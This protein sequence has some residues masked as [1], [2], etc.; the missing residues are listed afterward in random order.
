MSSLGVRRGGEEVRHWGRHRGM[1]GRPGGGRHRHGERGQVLVLF[2]LSMFVILGASAVAVDAS[3]WWYNQQ[4]MHRAA[5]AAALAGAI[6]LPGNPTAAANVAKAE[7]GK[8]DYLHGLQGVTVAAV[9]EPGNAR[10]L[11]VDIDGPVTT[12]FAQALGIGSVDASVSASAE[13]TL[14]VPMGSPQSYYGIYELV[15]WD[16]NDSHDPET[17]TV[18]SA[19]GTGTL[20]SQ[21]LWGAAITLG[22]TRGNGDAISPE[23][24]GSVA[25]P[26]HEAEGHHYQVIIPEGSSNGRVYLFDATFCAVGQD[27]EGKVYLGT[28]DHWIGTAARPVT[29]EFTLWDTH[30]TPWVTSDDTQR[31]YKIFSAENQV[32]KGD[33]RGNEEYSDGNYDGSSSADCSGDTTYHNT[34]WQLAGGLGPGRYRLQVQTTD[35]A[36]RSTNAENMY[37]I[38][39]VVDGDADGPRVHGL[40]RMVSYNNIDGSLATFYLAQIDAVHAGK[41]ME[42]RLFDPGDVGGN[43]YLR[44]KRPGAE[45]YSNAT[46]SYVATNG[47]SGT[48]VS[49]IQTAR[50]GSSL[51]NNHWITISVPLGSGYGQGTDDLT[52]AGESEPG[53]WK[54][55]YS[56]DRGGNDTT[57]WEVNLKGN[58]VHLVPVGG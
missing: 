2:T 3:W 34:W 57:T 37:G 20:T 30:D 42:I 41:T 38:Q 25:N 13:Y 27:P 28:G 58:P 33:F 43:A 7:A 19:S 6:H 11:R 29:T 24:N 52:P 9:P 14:P 32:D 36:N 31:A 4:M 54:I 23:N 17:T 21:G 16:G 10:R 15:S 49:V 40:G 5:E 55:E 45:T 50:N 48:T 18:P 51:F 53:W 47:S 22:G 12:F 1:Q 8:N 44:I 35:V 46:F 26:D 56:I 39:A